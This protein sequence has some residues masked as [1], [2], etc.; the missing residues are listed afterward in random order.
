MKKKKD[1]KIDIEKEN[2][3]SSNKY[4]I[5][6]ENKIFVGNKKDNNYFIRI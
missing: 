5:E 4:N 3:Q 6:E 1:K 2:N